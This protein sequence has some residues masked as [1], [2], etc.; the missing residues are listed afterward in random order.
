MDVNADPNNALM[1]VDATFKGFSRTLISN[2]YNV[3]DYGVDS[4]NN[5]SNNENIWS[6]YKNDI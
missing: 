1:L 5:L 2:D 6:Y 3:S 4:V